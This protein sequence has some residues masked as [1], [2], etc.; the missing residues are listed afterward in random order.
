MRLYDDFVE[1]QPGALARLNN[2]LSQSEQAQGSFTDSSESTHKLISYVL[3]SI[4]SSAWAF[5]FGRSSELPVKLPFHNALKDFT[6]AEVNQVQQRTEILYFLL[7]IGH[8]KYSTRLYHEP[9][10]EVETDKTVFMLLRSSFARR[11][12]RLLSLFS[13]RTVTRISLSRVC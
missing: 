9:V 5:L 11:R 13:C 2:Q 7:C 6:A 1:L 10:S 4:P 12:N 3:S 8:G